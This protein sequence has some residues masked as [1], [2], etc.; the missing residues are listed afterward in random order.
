[1]VEQSSSPTLNPDRAFDLYVYASGNAGYNRVLMVPSAAGKD[2][3]QALAT[4]VPGQYSAVKYTGANGLIGA[5]AGE[6]TG[7]YVKVMT[8]SP[9][10]SHFSLY[11]TS[12]TRPNAHCATAACNA[13]P[14]GAPGEDRLAKYIADNLPPAVFGDFAPP[15]AGIIDEDTW[16]QQ[17]VGLNQAYDRAVLN[18][19]LGTLQPDTDVLLA[20]TDQTDE[21]SHQILGLITPKAPDGTANPYYDRIAG[22]GPRD[23]RVAPAARLPPGRL[24]LG[25]RT[26]RP[27]PQPDRLGRGHPGQQRP[28]L[29]AAVARPSTPRCRSRNS[30]CRTSSRPATAGRPPP[31][32]RA[33]RS[34]R[35][36][37]RAAPPR[38]T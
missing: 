32:R 21:V 33:G 8:L 28:R 23:H 19:V 29:R 22:T 4:L 3:S 26:A 25:R 7:N 37:R 6:S 16:Y 17:T 38:S 9:D 12:L 14:A 5:A 11:F 15:E 1:M 13:L 20:G 35:S 24:S 34:R 31:A 2:G 10:L 27:D 30:A 18:F 36:A